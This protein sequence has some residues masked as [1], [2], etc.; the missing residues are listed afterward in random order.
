MVVLFGANRCPW[1][2]RLHRMFTEDQA[3]LARLHDDFVLVY[4]DANFRNDRKGNAVVLERY[5]DPIKKFG[6]PVLVVLG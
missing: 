4:V 2:R 1:C 3:I 6:L 5:G